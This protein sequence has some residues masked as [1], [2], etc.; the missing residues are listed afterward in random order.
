MRLV[1]VPSTE[2]LP[3]QLHSMVEAA[4]TCLILK[5][6]SMSR[7]QTAQER[8]TGTVIDDADRPVTC[9][10]AGPIIRAVCQL[11][12]LGVSDDTS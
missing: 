11:H 7:T 9:S 1:L 10:R 5:T 12:G 8:G 4:H 3:T 2:P 6:G